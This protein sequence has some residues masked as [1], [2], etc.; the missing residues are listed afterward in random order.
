MVRF[1]TAA[2]ALVASLIGITASGQQ[3]QLLD[4]WSPQCGP[5]MQ[6]KPIVHSYEQAGYPIRTVDTT[7]QKE[8]AVTE[9][10][11][12]EL[13]G[14]FYNLF[15]HANFELPGHVLGASNFGTVLSARPARAVQLG[16]RFSF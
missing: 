4:F 12:F 13:R 11:K 8:F 7:L 15:N 3:L 6:M 16:L 5:C 10:Y 2:I 14:E 9:R 1:A